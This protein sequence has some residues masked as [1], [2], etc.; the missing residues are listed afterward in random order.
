MSQITLLSP[1]KLNLFLHINFRRPDGYHELQTLFQ[2]LDYG[3]LLTFNLTDSS[4]ISI[5]P[6]VK[7]VSL[8]DNLIYKAATKLREQAEADGKTFSKPGIEI[9][10][11][12]KLPMGGGLGGGSSNAATTLIA[13]N[14]LWKLNYSL[15]QLATTGLQLGADVPV[16]VHGNSAYAEGVGEHLTPV[17]LPEIWYLVLHPGVHVSTANVFSHKQLTRDTPKSKIAPALEGDLRNIA[18]YCDLMS[19]DCQSIVCQ[20]YPEIRQ[21]IDWLSQFSPAKLTGTGACIFASFS[22]K[23]RADN[24]LS[25]LPT[26]Y[27]GFVA[28]GINKSPAFERL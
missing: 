9:F 15:D 21:A 17:E 12:K 1:A 23:Q 20:L 7:G 24:V 25:Q 19:N 27:Q 18:N 28:K 13:L 2:L 3:D 10:I 6:E 22:D 11:G 5:T 14:H 16:F 26:N 4:D 8:E